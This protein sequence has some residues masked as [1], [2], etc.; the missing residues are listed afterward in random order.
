MSRVRR[1]EAKLREEMSLKVTLYALGAVMLS[2]WSADSGRAAPRSLLNPPRG[3]LISKPTAAAIG[4]SRPRVAQS[5]RFHISTANHVLS[6]D[7]TESFR[8][9]DLAPPAAVA[10]ATS[11][12]GAS[13]ASLG[14]KAPAFSMPHTAFSSPPAA[15]Q[16]LTG[17]S[18]LTTPRLQP[19]NPP[20]IGPLANAAGLGGGLH[21]S[22]SA[23][24][25]IGG[26]AAR[27]NIGALDGTSF[28]TKR[29]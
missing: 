22:I 10:N 7:R 25:P 2:L 9:A 24:V 15:T 6:N 1:I 12:R 8:K 14:S 3:S 5:P 28:H 29:R 18:H 27:S 13:V 21:H 23:L 16:S 26:A 19:A 20:R 4:L 11:P 17:P